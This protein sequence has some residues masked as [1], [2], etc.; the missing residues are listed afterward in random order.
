MQA[1]FVGPL[2]KFEGLLSRSVPIHVNG[3]AGRPHRGVTYCC[4]GS[5]KEVFSHRQMRRWTYQ[6]L[7]FSLRECLEAQGHHAMLAPQ[8]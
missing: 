6:P 4:K 1:D 2:D 7:N 8:L 3:V 5:Y